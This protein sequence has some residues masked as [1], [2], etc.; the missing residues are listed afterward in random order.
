MLVGNSFPHFKDANGEPLESGY[1]YIGAINLNPETNPVSVYWDADFTIPAVQP[2]RTLNGYIVHNGAI[3]NVYVA[4]TYSI[5]VRNK[6]NILLYS[7]PNSEFF[8]A[9]SLLNANSIK[10]VD[11]IADLKALSKTETPFASVFG[12]YV[13]GDGG[14]GLYYLDALDT[15][16]ADNGGSVIVATDGGRWK[17]QD[18]T[19]YD[20][21]QFGA[22]GDGVTVDTLSATN[23]AATGKPITA[24]YG[25]YVIDDPVTFSAGLHGM[26]ADDGQT[27]FTLT[28]LGQL[29]VGDWQAEWSGFL[30]KSAVNNKT[31][32]KNPGMS[33]WR[34]TNFRLEATGGAT[35]QKGIEFDTTTASI[36]SCNI[37]NFK[38]KL[39]YPCFITGNTTQV[40]N[41]NCIGKSTA[42]YWQSFATAITIENQLACD[43]NNFEGYLETGTNAVGLNI[44]AVRQNRFKFVLDAVTNACNCATAV[45]T[46]N[47]WEILDGGFTVSGTYPQNQILVGPPDTKVRATDASATGVLTSAAEKTMLFDTEVFDSLTEF[48]HTTGIFTAKNTGFYLVEVQ[49][50]SDVYA[51]PS[52][53]R[54]EA[55]IYKNAALF[56][57]SR[58]P[59]SE[60]T[61]AASIQMTTKC[62]S[63]VN[64]NG[65]ETIT[66][67]LV[68]NRGAN[69][70]LIADAGYNFINITRV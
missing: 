37:D 18:N 69:T 17:L 9:S 33:Y 31:F 27:S 52:G 14:G 3:A 8:D 55:R 13:P 41:A 57:K 44:V 22:K 46:A 35:G 56:A 25:D 58:S 26:G 5:T 11:S 42:C 49:A 61:S 12:Y 53:T 43:A 64:L 32:I 1:V 7:L 67:K 40:F 62:S 50:T 54:L 19:S 24:S 70:N 38:I 29:I 51:W 16:T 39:S 59:D 20:L 47:L 28:S 66:I 63:I 10:S 6:V 60:T 36:Y 23:A 45:I 21:R 30:V 65:G 68:H 34:F 2:L 4:G 48:V 15:T